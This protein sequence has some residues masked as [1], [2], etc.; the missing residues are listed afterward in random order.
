MKLFK[1]KF[2][3]LIPLL[4]M[5]WHA[6]NG[7]LS[8]KDYL[9]GP[10]P[11]NARTDS[12]ISILGPANSIEHTV[13]FCG[14]GPI[15]I[16]DSVVPGDTVYCDSLRVYRYDSLTICTDNHGAMEYYFFTRHGLL[17]KRGIGIGDLKTKVLRAYGKPDWMDSARVYDERLETEDDH[18]QY[19]NGETYYGIAFFMFNGKVCRIFIGRG[20]GC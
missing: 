19:G 3:V 14:K 10:I 1:Q 5:P 7:T 15:M 18:L 6:Q 13:G 11:F 4:A 2:L 8:E 12:L 17:T 16:G 9:L 20:E